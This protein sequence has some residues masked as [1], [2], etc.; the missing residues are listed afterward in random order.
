MLPVTV[1]FLRRT[2]LPMKYENV[3]I[4]RNCRHCFLNSCYYGKVE[5]EFRSW[6]WYALVICG[7]KFFGLEKIWLTRFRLEGLAHLTTCSNK[8]NAMRFLLFRGRKVCS[9]Y[10]PS[11]SSVEC[12]LV[13]RGEM[14][15]IYSCLCEMVSE[16]I[17]LV[18]DEDGKLELWGGCLNKTLFW[19]LKAAAR[20]WGFFGVVVTKPRHEQLA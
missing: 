4:I 11:Q 20:R 8:R 5:R 12:G 3:L 16:W 2:V 10:V 1:L 6:R 7:G 14:V 15:F 19:E 13:W 18:V 17:V 9:W